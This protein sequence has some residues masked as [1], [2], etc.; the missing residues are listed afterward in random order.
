MFFF[1]L[2][3]LYFCIFSLIWILLM[4]MRKETKE[5][6]SIWNKSIVSPWSCHIQNQT[7][8]YCWKHS[9][10]LWIYIFNSFIFLSNLISKLHTCF[11]NK[12]NL[13]IVCLFFF[14]PFYSLWFDFVHH[15]L[16][17]C[18]HLVWRHLFIFF[19]FFCH[20][21]AAILGHCFVG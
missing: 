14:W 21:N 4:Q 17:Q 15:P 20:W 16:W 19:T 9:G 13:I 10:I 5:N 3:W 6:D 2:F 7:T 11:D 8:S 12:M 1:Y 18:N